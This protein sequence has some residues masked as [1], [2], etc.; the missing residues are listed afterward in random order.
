M[1]LILTICAKELKQFF[2][3]PV[4]YI[5]LIAYFTT[6]AWFFFRSFFVTDLATFR[7]FF[8][9][10][11]W[12]FLFLVPAISMRL[13]SE[14]KKE[15]TLDFIFTLPIKDHQLIFGKFLANAF[16]LMLCLLLTTPLA[17]V[18]YYMGSPDTGLIITGYIALYLLSLS[19]LSVGMWV[20]S[21]TKN[22]I[23]AFI[24]SLSICFAFFLLGTSAVL[25]SVPT[26]LA[27]IFSQLSLGSHFNQV[28][29]GILDSR[30]ILFFLS[31]ISVFLFLNAQVFDQR[32][33]IK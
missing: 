7:S 16:L 33:V 15:G 25:Y 1:R 30:N 31:F 2:S 4:A 9:F 6:S 17:G 23:I 14:E 8:D 10:S 11:P 29:R 5:Y 21:L 20:S 19:Y 24:G 28:I 18:V 32:K 3:S 27:A 22:Q 26:S 12:V 13:W